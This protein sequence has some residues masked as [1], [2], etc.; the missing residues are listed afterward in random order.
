MKY[1]K[2]LIITTVIIFVIVI[3]VAVW[4]YIKGE[5]NA[6]D[7]DFSMED[8]EN[9]FFSNDEE[10]LEESKKNNT[11]YVSLLSE[12][13]KADD[14]SWVIGQHVFTFKKPELY[15]LELKILADRQHDVEDGFLYTKCKVRVTDSTV[16]KVNVE[17]FYDDKNQ[18]EILDENRKP[19]TEFENG[20]TIVFKCPEDTD[21]SVVE[22]KF[23]V[24]FL[25]DN[26]K[27]KVFA[28]PGL[29]IY[30]QRYGK[31]EAYFN[32]PGTEERWKDGTVRFD[33]IFPGYEKTQFI[34]T[35]NTGLYGHVTYLNVPV[36]QYKLTK[37][38]DGKDVESETFEIKPA[39]T[40]TVEF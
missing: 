9:L 36:G 26:K 13:A 32:V 24:E 25:H 30:Y 40:T 7:F 34:C 6:I 8:E 11:D 16:T 14:Y 4:I 17:K 22:Y 31:V 28:T 15:G 1:K 19:K 20:E 10:E 33:R 27:Y 12:E 37:V 38:I 39:E 5:E 35:S 2:A 29:T 23:T 21:F 3:A 18:I